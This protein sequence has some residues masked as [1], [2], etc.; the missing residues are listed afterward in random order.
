MQHN[1][2][3]VT[4]VSILSNPGYLPRLRRI[5]SC[6]ADCAGMDGTEVNDAKL[7]ITE[8][9]SNAIRHGS[10][11][12]ALDRVTVRLLAGAGAV[13]A[14]VRDVGEGFDRALVGSHPVTQPGGLGISLMERLTD[15]VE[16][17]REGKGM[18]V[19]MVKRAKPRPGLRLISG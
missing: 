11:G 6:L 10:P 7:A 3:T 19:R 4:E 8:A 16:F 13:V 2:G 9:C 15:K 1:K 5:V 17:V 18:T 12:G 14:E